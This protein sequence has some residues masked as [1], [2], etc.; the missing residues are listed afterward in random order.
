MCRATNKT[1]ALILISLYLLLPAAVFAHANLGQEIQG[2][3]LTVTVQESGVPCDGCPCTGTQDADCC[4]NA[5]PCCCHVPLAQLV[6]IAYSPFVISLNHPEYHLTSPQ[7][8]LS[9]YVPPQ[10]LS[11]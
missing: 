6:T 8:Y 2:S 4:E 9:I 11:A 5:C 7:V 1:L 10:N 3:A